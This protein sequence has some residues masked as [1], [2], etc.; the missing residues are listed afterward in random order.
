MHLVNHCG[1]QSIAAVHFQRVHRPY[2]NLNRFD[3]WLFSSLRC[4]VDFGCGRIAF[5][6]HP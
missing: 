4:V 5:L 6:A 3:L 1:A 2:K